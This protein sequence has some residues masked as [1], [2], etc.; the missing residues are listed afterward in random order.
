MRESILVFPTCQINF[1]ALTLIRDFDHNCLGT[2]E[3]IRTRIYLINPEWVC[4][5]RFLCACG[6]FFFFFFKKKKV[7]KDRLH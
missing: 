6:V 7:A 4:S 5:L 1:V 3:C 2:V